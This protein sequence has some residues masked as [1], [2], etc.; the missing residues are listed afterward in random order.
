MEKIY[1]ILSKEFH[2]STKKRLR[3]TSIL[4]LSLL[5][6]STTLMA[7]TKRV[8]KGRVLDEKKE[9]LIGATVLVK[10]LKNVGTVTDLNGQF[11]LSVPSDK[12][13]L[14]VSFVS[15]KTLEV[16]VAGKN[17]VTVL[18]SSNTHQM[19]ELVVVG[20]G[21]Q[22]KES[23]VAAITQTKGEVLERAGGVS[24]IGSAL[25]GNLPGVIT[26]ATSGAPGGEDP[27]IFIRGQSTWNNSDPLVLVDGIE[28]PMNSVD[29][30]SVASISVL[31]D[32]SATAVFGVKGAN[33]V[34]L[35][36]T[37][38]GK[39]GK[40]D[41][42]VAV[43]TTLKVP[44]RL[45]TKYDSYDALRI[46]NMAI[47]RELGLYSTSWDKYTPYSELNKYRNPSSQAEAERYPNVDWADE[48]VNKSAMSHN[49]NIN[50]SG[51]T[52]SVRYF[53]SIDYL[54]EGDILKKIDAGKSYDPGYGYQ[55]LNVRSNLDFDLTK[56]TLLSV[57][58]SGSYGVKQDTYNQDA[59]EYR[60][61]QSI[62]S[63]A[64]D[65]YYPHYS[66]GTWGYYPPD[67]VSTINSALTL[68]NNGVRKT[69][70]KRINTDFSLR[71]DLSMITKG[72]S[73]KA[74]ISLDNSFQSVGG[75]YDNGNVQQTYIDPVTGEVKHSNYLGTNQFDW[76][77]TRWSANTDAANYGATYRK[78]FYQAQLDYA[79]KFGKHEVS[80]L[81]LFS[82]DQSAGGSVFPSY[83]EDWVS[84]LTYNYAGK[85]FAEFN[86]A[87]NGSEKF[88]PNYRFA[89]FPSTAF[90]WMLSEEKLVKKLN[91]LDM[92]KVRASWGQVGDDN[93]SNRFLYV[94]EWSYGGN[95]P[96]GA[97]AGTMSP[98]TWWTLKKLGN[99]DIHWEKVTKT[100]V[101]IDYAFLKGLF[102]GSVEFFND[103]RTDI[104]LDG[105]Q[106]AIPG[107]FGGN[108]ATANLGEVRVKGYELSLRLNKKL[109]KDFRVWG[110]FSMTHAK[111]K[112]LFADDP[113]LKDD[114]QKRAGKQI[115]QSYSYISSGYYNTWDQVY[116]S[117]QLK[118]YDKEKLPGNLNMVDYN[119]DG[120]VDDKDNVPYGYP[121]RPQNTYNATIGVEWK[122]FSAF[123]QFYGVNNCNRYLSLGSFSAHLDRVY[124][125]GSYWTKD[126][127]NADVPMPRW[128]SHMDYSGTNYLYDGSYVRLK[129][130]EIAYTF[131]QSYLKKFGINTLRLYLNGDNLI[132]WTKM[133]D[134]REVNMGLSS[135]YPTV[136]RFN[137][138]L[139]VTF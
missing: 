15:Y 42:R 86:G 123:V 33:G 104:L 114:Y 17:S 76:L 26:V 75:I 52:S 105:S 6:F 65:I 128:N 125:Q 19:D 85:Y 118:T 87:Y 14:V 110:E 72:L 48:L 96:L 35:I 3:Q 40:A 120:V 113:Q 38:R 41:I 117:T 32:A 121:E 11:V 58:L 93:I 133:P 36:T 88:G 34:I 135:A 30:S 1:G 71:Q 90:G 63:S 39:E 70:N 97:Q 24:N 116:G 56:T 54:N 139:N 79:R 126:D 129:N 111:D 107:Y 27:K 94:N 55:R 136:R 5:F 103:H 43:N 138:G 81:G 31:K 22:K 29:I 68:A 69:T 73:A 84:R 47:E 83:R 74:L 16:N 130:A 115:G 102:A 106:R 59:W 101:G 67:P 99:P 46:R 78:M 64:P 44:S 61:W 98:Y 45:A 91:I 131:N 60:I 8:I 50:I 66:D 124:H 4:L 12:Q 49:A 122:H 10:G 23:V 51:G 57:N 127:T 53:T 89:F 2:I 28:R 25:T 62:Y 92:L 109:N 9:P 13:T 18:L 21:Q 95:S 108:P 119:A 100:N 82:R 132:M 20:Y 80:G 134:D 37:K 137:L 112:V 7:Q 77:P